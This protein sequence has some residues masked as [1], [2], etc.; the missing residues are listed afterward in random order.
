MQLGRE[1]VMQTSSSVT[2]PFTIFVRALSVFLV[3]RYLF[4]VRID[5]PTAR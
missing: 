3:G 1:Y 2:P 5:S 4:G